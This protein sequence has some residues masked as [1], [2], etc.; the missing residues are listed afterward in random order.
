MGTRTNTIAQEIKPAS[1]RVFGTTI[2]V[3]K[4]PEHAG[5]LVG[6]CTRAQPCLATYHQPAHDSHVPDTTKWPKRQPQQ[7]PMVPMP[8]SLKSASMAWQCRRMALSASNDVAGTWK[9]FSAAFSSP[10][11]S[12]ITPLQCHNLSFMPEVHEV[13]KHAGGQKPPANILFF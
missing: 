10:T 8:M 2:P 11:C 5:I 1:L 12:P 13:P 6:I 3:A 7:P 9:R 4:V